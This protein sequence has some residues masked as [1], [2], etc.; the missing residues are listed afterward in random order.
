MRW[1]FRAPNAGLIYPALN[2]MQGVKSAKVHTM[3]P[4]YS[5]SAKSAEISAPCLRKSLHVFLR[6]T[7]LQRR[8]HSLVCCLLCSSVNRAEECS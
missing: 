5:T 1:Y 8:E 3:F 6:R 7:S 4:N 2:C